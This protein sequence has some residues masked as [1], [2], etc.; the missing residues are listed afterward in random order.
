[1][2]EVL[3]LFAVAVTSTGTLLVG[4][5]WLGLR[6]AD[7][8]WAARQALECVGL[9]IGFFVMNLTVGVTMVFVGRQLL[10]TFVSI[11]FVNDV[12]LLGIY[13]LQAVL[14]QWWRQKP[15]SR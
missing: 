12:A 9:S 7:L 11:Y 13:L 3:V 6:P 14:F 8:R 1:M 15:Q 4:T 2:A 5:A 10:D